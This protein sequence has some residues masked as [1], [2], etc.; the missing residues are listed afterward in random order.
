MGTSC[1]NT[2]PRRGL[3]RI[4]VGVNPR[5]SEP[6]RIRP[7][8]GRMILRFRYRRFHLRLFTFGLSEADSTVGQLYAPAVDGLNPRQQSGTMRADRSEEHTSELQSP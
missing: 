1:C 4:A 2:K 7:R 8:R 5:I 3:I 6:S